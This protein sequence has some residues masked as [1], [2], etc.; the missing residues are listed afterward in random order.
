MGTSKKTVVIGMSGGVDSSVAA[1]LLKRDYNVIGISLQVFDYSDFKECDLKGVCCSPEDV[2]DARQVAL[3]LSIPF[4]VLNYREKFKRIVIDNFISEYL[5]GNTPNPCIICN[6]KIKF[7]EMLNFA[8]S[9]GADFIAT[10]HYAINTPMN[11]IRLLRMGR[12]KH[13][14][15]SY[16]LYRLN[17]EKLKKILF[18]IGNLTKEEVRKI[19][20]ENELNIYNK[21]E[22]HEICFVPQ[23]NYSEL[24]DKNIKT[25]MS[26]KIISSNGKVLGRH[27]GYYRYTIGQRR[28]LNINSNKPLYV[29][30]INAEEKEIVVGEEKELY[31]N[32]F[33]IDNVNFI[34]KPEKIEDLDN[35]KV[36]IRYL[37]EPEYCKIKIENNNKVFVTTKMP[38]RAI[39]PGQSAVFY[40][41][42]IVL[43]GGIISEV[44]H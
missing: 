34:Y 39:T 26:G 28:G 31:S 10:G 33:I 36:K 35:V 42:D 41:E 37:S 11:S 12:D 22:S 7:G 23:N 25:D 18:P 27:K 24:I 21:R 2:Y 44:I 17:Q 6:E 30:K 4:Y 13:K 15:Q 38:L 5:N 3:K 32:S 40:I 8:I 19:A 9:I 20:K 16:F 14:D 29:I 1:L 43:G